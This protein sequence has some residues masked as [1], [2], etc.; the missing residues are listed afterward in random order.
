MQLNDRAKQL[1][2]TDNLHFHM[3]ILAVNFVNVD[4][5]KLAF[6]IEIRILYRQ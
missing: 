1:N 5:D 2:L 3:W 6:I 4:I